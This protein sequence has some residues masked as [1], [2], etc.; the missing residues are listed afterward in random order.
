[1]FSP[2]GTLAGVH[3]GLEIYRHVNS[4]GNLGA[5]A[6]EQ[7]FEM[8]VWQFRDWIRRVISGEGTSNPGHDELKRRRLAGDN[9]GASLPMT[10]PPEADVCDAGSPACAPSAPAWAP[11]V[12]L[13]AGNYRGTAMARCASAGNAACSFNGTAYA[14]GASARLLLGPA[15]APSAPGTREVVVWCKTTTAFPDP[16]SPA[17]DVLRL[18]FTNAEHADVVIGYGWWDM[19]PDQV[20]TG[21]GQTLVNTGPLDTCGSG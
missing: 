2:P 9:S 12:L 7:P 16:G 19:T 20:G 11:G 10:L 15:S 4:S 3:R 17:R 13:G 8:P 14:E 1:M 5:P 18:S 6:Y 21:T